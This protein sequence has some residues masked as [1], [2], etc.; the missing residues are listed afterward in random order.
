MIIRVCFYVER[1]FYERN[2]FILTKVKAIFIIIFPIFVTQMS[3]F[4]M[5]F[6][7][8]TMSGHASPIDLAGVAI[9]TS[10]WLPVSTGL[11]GIL[12]A[13]TPIVA[14]LV[15]SK[16]K[17]DVPHIVIQAV[18]LAICASFVVIL[19]GFF[20]VSPILNGMQ[21]E[22]P[23]ERIAAHF[24]SIIAIGIIPLFTY[25]VLRGFIDA[26]GKTRTTM[27][28]TLLSLPI[29]VVLNYSINF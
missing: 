16:K 22:E 28:I 7:D 4:S 1:G 20:A 5:S 27:I 12:M 6:F 29:N 13:T 3:L 8:T 14:Q 19:I 21:L 9:G 10:I 2:Y 25:T 15:G 18:Y 24:L 17:E 26:L 23:V 11:T